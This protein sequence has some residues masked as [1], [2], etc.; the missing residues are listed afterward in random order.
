[1]KY[2]TFKCGCSFPYYDDDKGRHV[3]L[4]LDWDSLNYNCK[5]TYELISSGNCKGIFQVE[6]SLGSTCCKEAPVETMDDIANIISVMR[7]GSS[8]A[9]LDDG[10]NLT[11]HYLLRRSGREEVT[12]LHPA[13]EPHLKN[14]Y[15][16]LTFQEQVSSIVK[17]IAGFSADEADSLRAAAAKKKTDLM[18]KM[19][20]LFIDGCKKIGKVSEADAVTIWQWIE[21]G[22]RYL[23]N[24]SH[25]YGYAYITY[26]TAYIK[27]HFP[28]VFFNSWLSYAGEK[29]DKQ[30]E[31]LELVNNA[32]KM[33]IHIRRPDFRK[34]NQHFTVHEDGIYFG[35][36]EVK[37]IGKAAFEKIEVVTAELEQ[38]IGPKTHW[39]YLDHLVLLFPRLNSTS[40]KSMI[41]TGA[42]DHVSTSRTKLGYD[43][44]ILS[45]LS[46]KELEWAVENYKTYSDLL[47]LL[48]GLVESFKWRGTARKQKVSELISSLTNP[49]YSMSDSISVLSGEEKRLLGISLTCNAIDA[50]DT[51]QANCEIKDFLNGRQ[52]YIMIAAHIDVAREN[53]IKKGNAAG[54]KMGFLTLSD[55]SG[56]MDNVVCFADGWKKYKGVLTSGNT[57]MIGGSRSKKNGSLVVDKVWQI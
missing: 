57:V 27:A 5:A 37:G 25:A 54:M 45:E 16:I 15:A 24:A 31:I 38:Q 46:P 29:I 40:V 36:N 18:A 49:P 42:F 43:Y 34:L 10:K 47:S 39:S 53:T 22:A 11:T 48:I 1:M 41:S 8:E 33:D 21:A 26:F 52:D 13:L 20:S 23:F 35:F 28:S 2:L 4:S 56:S 32:K 19:K 3:D 14:T 12:Y 50:C 30:Q 55:S 9:F 7:P 6:S 51:S 44:S 17:D